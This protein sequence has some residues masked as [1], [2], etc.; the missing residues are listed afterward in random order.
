MNVRKLPARISGDHDAARNF[1]KSNPD[2]PQFLRE[3]AAARDQAGTTRLRAPG[4][5]PQ[6]LPGPHA[7]RRVNRRGGE[8]PHQS[9]AHRR[10]EGAAIHPTPL[11]TTPSGPTRNNLTALEGENTPH[12]YQDPSVQDAQH[13][14]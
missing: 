7:L 5:A 9:L 3:A 11:S 13:Q 4:P 8:H 2:C 10:R 14:D 6:P 12:D 1:V